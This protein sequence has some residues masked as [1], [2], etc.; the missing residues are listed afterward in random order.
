MKLPVNLTSAA[1]AEHKPEVYAYL[2][3]HAPVHEARIMRL[4]K[5]FVL[6]RYED[7]VSMLKDARFVR[8]RSVANGGGRRSPFPMPKS[9]TVLMNSMI[10]VDE[11]DHRRL[12]ALVHKA[13]IPRMLD[14]LEGRIET[15][16]H[17]LLDTLEPRGEFDVLRD[18]AHPIPVTVIAEMV[19]V[20]TDEIPE[21]AGFMDSLAE[22]LTGFRVAKTM[23]WDMPRA[24]RFMRGLIERKRREPADDILTRLIEAEENGER[25]SEDELIAMVFLLI[26][27]GYETTYNL[28]ANAVQTLLTHPE[29]LEELRGD[30]SLMAS[31]IEEVL[32]FNGPV[33]G[34]KPGYPTEDVQL[35][36]VTI[37]KG[38]MVMPLLG[39]ANL[40]PRVFEQAERFDIRRTPNRH[41]GFG[42]GI[43]YCLG[44]PLARLETRIALAAL[45]ERNQALQLAV[46]PAA[47]SL[48]ARPGWH[49]YTAVPV[50]VR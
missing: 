49:I 5:V 40:D 42:M 10:N 4:M 13:F 15:L 7:C 11:P 27:A 22:G 29:S 21:F 38:A 2:R 37:P 8:D 46:E 48:V 33:H 1:F 18:F 16:S 36:G 25:L 20:H 12:R 26:V 45:L 6:S 44:A 39:A 28:I 43:H 47:L 41:L 32:R 19:G 35:H 9:V 3:E 31:T 50:R 24:I 23:L 17:E 34:T 30:A 14:T